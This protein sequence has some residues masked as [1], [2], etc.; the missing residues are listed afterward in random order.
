MKPIDERQ[1][2][3]LTRSLTRAFTMNKPVPSQAPTPIASDYTHQ[4]E[5]INHVIGDLNEKL[6]DKFHRRESKV[7]DEY[8]NKL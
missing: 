3:A 4:Y 1:S 8:K 2:R 7:L 6:T 5:Q